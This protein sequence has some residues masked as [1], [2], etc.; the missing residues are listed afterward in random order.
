MPEDQA[1]PVGATDY[2]RRSVA[3]NLNDIAKDHPDIVIKTAKSWFGHNKATNW[4][5]KHACRTLLK[6]GNTEV[7]AIFGFG[8][9]AKVQIEK[10]Q[11]KKTSLVI[12]ND[13]EF[14]FTVKANQAAKLRVE[15]GIDYMK[16]NGSTSRKIFQINESEYAQN[17]AKTFERKQSLKN[18]TTRKHYPGKHHLVIIVNGVEKAKVDFD[19]A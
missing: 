15:Y 18:M 13:L 11:L 6:Q 16:A 19:L 1:M 17:E 2:V 5:V 10:L 4:I 9:A 14:S 3:N 7:L 12:G 8:N